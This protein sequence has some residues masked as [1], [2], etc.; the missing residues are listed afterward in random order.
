MEIS[1]LSLTDKSWLAPQLFTIGEDLSEYSFS[2]LFL[3]RDK[4]HYRLVKVGNSSFLLGF[5]Y[6]GVAYLMPT[7]AFS[8][9]SVQM[10]QQVIATL[11]EVEMIFPVP[12][13]A[14]S[15][16]PSEL[17]Q[18]ETLPA[19]MDYLF[20]REKLRDFP[21]RHLHGKRNLVKQ[22]REGCSALSLPLDSPQRR[23]EAALILSTWQ[24]DSTLPPEKTDFYACKEA[25][26]LYDELDLEGFLFF[27]GET[28]VAFSLGE[29]IAPSVYGLHFAKANKRFKGAYQYLFSETARLMDSRY[30]WLNLEQDLGNAAL[31]SAKSSYRP[32]K[33][34]K[35]YRLFIKK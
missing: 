17:F 29:A 23:S 35:K 31:R 33:M 21:G 6:D 30:N 2:N 13:S 24:E 7:V 25:L 15:F 34:G 5:S 10:L 27:A 12:E 22:F 28:P 16:F 20:T 3:F 14:L 32:D 11:P 8:K 1:N 26:R 4:H 19:D 18:I 9:Q